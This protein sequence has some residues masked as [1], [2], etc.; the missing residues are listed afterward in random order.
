MNGSEVV[1]PATSHKPTKPR[2]REA[3]R[4][5]DVRKAVQGA[6]AGGMPVGRIRFHRGGFELYAQD[7]SAPTSAADDVERRMQEAFGDDGD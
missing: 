5:D 4:K 2:A 6:I 3:W 1:T 7:D